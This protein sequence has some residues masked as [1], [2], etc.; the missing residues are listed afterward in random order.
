VC[1]RRNFLL[2]TRPTVTGN[3][4]AESGIGDQQYYIYGTLSLENMWVCPVAIIKNMIKKYYIQFR[5]VYIQYE[6]RNVLKLHL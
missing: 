2:P 1:K 3:R 4:V 6:R 5:Y